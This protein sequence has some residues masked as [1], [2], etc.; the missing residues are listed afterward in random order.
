MKKVLLILI[1]T[2]LVSMSVC[3]NEIVRVN[4]SF[5]GDDTD[6]A[7]SGYA[8][9]W[10]S[11][12]EYTA[13]DVT[14]TGFSFDKNTPTAYI[15]AGKGLGEAFTG[16]FEID[17]DVYISELASFRVYTRHFTTRSSATA[18]TGMI[19]KE[20]IVSFNADGTL[21]VNK[22]S[23]LPSPSVNLGYYIPG[24][25]YS[26]KAVYHGSDGE[27]GSYSVYLTSGMIKENPE[28][29]AQKKEN[30][31]AGT[32]DLE[33]SF[34]G[35]GAIYFK[36][37]TESETAYAILDNFTVIQK[38]AETKADDTV[39]VGSTD[40]KVYSSNFILIDDL[41]KIKV[42]KNGIQ[43]TEGTDYTV[44]YEL[45]TSSSAE[46]LKWC[47]NPIVVLAS[48]VADREYYVVDI[49][50]L[51]DING[52]SF[53]NPYF[54]MPVPTDE[55]IFNEMKLSFDSYMDG[56]SELSNDVSLKTSF[57]SEL[58]AQFS[59]DV[60]YEIENTSNMAED[61]Y[62]QIIS[63]DNNSY[64]TVNRPQAANFEEYQQLVSL[65]GKIKG[66][67]K[68]NDLPEYTVETP[69]VVKK[70]NYFESYIQ[71]GGS[72]CNYKAVFDDDSETAM[73]LP[74]STE[75]SVQLDK[76]KAFGGFVA[77]GDNI[78]SYEIFYLDL[79]T[80]ALVKFN[81]EAIITDKL[82]FK[83]NGTDINLKSIFAFCTDE[84][85]ER[86][87]YENLLKTYPFLFD[88]KKVTDTSILLPMTIYKY[89]N[90]KWESEDEIVI[91]IFGNIF[92]QNSE[93]TV[94]LTAYLLD[95]MGEPIIS[96]ARECT[97]VVPAKAITDKKG[98]G[99]GGGS[100][101][102][103]GL[104]HFGGSKSAG[105]TTRP[106]TQN[107]L[108]LP[109][110]VPKLPFS[111]VYESYWGYEAI[112]YLYEN[113]IVNGKTKTSFSPEDYIT[114]EEFVKMLIIASDITGTEDD[115]SFK[116]VEYEEWY[117]DYIKAAFNTGVVTGIA[118]NEFGI[119]SNITRQ[120]ICV[121]LG[122]ALSYLNYNITTENYKE[123]KDADRISDYALPYINL[124]TSADVV[125]GYS[126]GTIKPDAYATRAECAKIIYSFMDLTGLV[127]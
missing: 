103:S 45:K 63:L 80:E 64:V 121:M 114:R 78:S 52:F 61:D 17:F 27:D 4:Y 99:S 38:P 67:L 46:K 92:N 50:A 119:G 26:F 48:P 32:F 110:V 23:N 42:S 11:F 54:T 107:K 57:S 84:L 82:V 89:I 71:E 105:A 28:S 39:T 81:D 98:T 90:L 60:E 96:S 31:L 87:S 97:V 37:D 76:P 70:Y 118:K 33:S 56:L 115:V 58:F 102:S 124:L 7:F 74:Q 12:M 13:G 100:S 125:S 10:G 116:D 24:T 14:D 65:S 55:M 3:A 79:N 41:S 77:E 16:N 19:Y 62:S 51:T 75:I 94:K 109:P 101:G 9:E 15:N 18:N 30:L 117:Y 120:D 53:S 126:D 2:L 22:G 21:S 113:N 91:S 83:I 88:N 40:L 1:F 69:F 44:S 25:A 86:F 72:L 111:D 93:R 20:D 6:A 36:I 122:R 5:N 85:D 34:G 49:S 95:E 73:Q 104:S 35:V 106:A 66:T 47:V 43:L 108:E 29:D 8:G 59:A 68:Y 123:Y 112:K 127:D